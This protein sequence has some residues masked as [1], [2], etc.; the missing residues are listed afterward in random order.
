MSE[1]LAA[2]AGATRWRYRAADAQGAMSRGEL[3]AVSAAEAVDL[4]RRRALWVIDL[5]PTAGASSAA[6][7][8]A[9][10]V[11]P[12]AAGVFDRVSRWTTDGGESLAILTRSVATLLE[13]G[14]PLE[15]AL[16]FA[17]SGESDA[18]WQQIFA[19]LQAA[20]TRG[21]SL[22]EAAGRT[23]ALP[24]AYAPLL[25]AAEASGSM[26]ATFARL[27]DDLEARSQ[28]RARVRAALV[29][30]TLLALASTVGTL[31]ILVVVVP[32]FADLI[33][34]AGGA[35][36]AST[37]LLIGLSALLS[38]F[39]WLAVV[40]VLLAGTAVRQALQDAARR[41]RWHAARLRWPLVGRFERELAAAGYLSTLAVAL[42]SGVPLLRAM[43]LAR[44]TV[45]NEALSERLAG[46]ETAVR[47]GGSVSLALAGSLTPLATRLLEAGEQGG[48]LAPLARRAATAAGDQVQRVITSAVALIEP[49]MILGFG[50]VVGFVALALLQAIYG[51][52]AS[53]F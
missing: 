52:N 35:V 45:G 49:I 37:R 53:S 32:R 13:A 15:R 14:V 8:A 9:S 42:E 3:E 6:S 33:A 38:R 26:A 41:R 11:S 50:G 44:G 22:S 51:I 24:R 25:A 36:P 16:A 30:P 19:G 18:R 23:E 10:T 20:V 43:A 5:E 48:A 4:L 27:A 7:S 28:L 39:G 12:T 29:Y 2:S 47:D 46:A 17:A 40:A 21:E 31:V 1:R 34:G